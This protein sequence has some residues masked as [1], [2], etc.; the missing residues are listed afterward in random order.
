MVVFVFFFFLFRRLNLKEKI[1][2]DQ[3]SAT[4]SLGGNE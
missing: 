2:N 4:A 3:E 1:S